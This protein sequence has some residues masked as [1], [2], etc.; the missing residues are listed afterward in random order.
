M[1]NPTYLHEAIKKVGFYILLVE[2]K[3]EWLLIK[4][5]RSENEVLGE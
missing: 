4:L 3:L 2:L 5:E 1:N